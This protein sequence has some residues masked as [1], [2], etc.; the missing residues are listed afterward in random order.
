[1]ISTTFIL[2][3]DGSHARLFETDEPK[4][5]W[6]LVSKHDQAHSHEKTD[7]PDTHE[8]RTEHAFARLLAASLETLREQGKL[9]RL[10]LAAPAKFLGMLRGELPAPLAALV[11]ASVDKDFTHVADGAIHEHVTVPLG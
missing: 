3:G 10:V 11:V 8:D 6:R 9:S 7:R 4:R 1:M 2:V 5:P